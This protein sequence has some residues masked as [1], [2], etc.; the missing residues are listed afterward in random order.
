MTAITLSAPGAKQE[1][2]LTQEV[3]RQLDDRKVL[4][5]VLYIEDYALPRLTVGGSELVGEEILNRLDEI[6][7]IAT[8]SK[9]R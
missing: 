9:V 7:Q 2:K 3:L 5:D 1:S 4:Y 6:Q 8:S